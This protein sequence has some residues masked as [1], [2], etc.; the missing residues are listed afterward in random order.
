MI[1]LETFVVTKFD[2]IL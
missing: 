1:R 2:K